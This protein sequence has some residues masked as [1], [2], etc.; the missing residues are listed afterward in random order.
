MMSEE[1]G[2]A[3][4]L[5]RSECKELLT[6][7]ESIGLADGDFQHPMLSQMA[8]ELRKHG[9]TLHGN[10]VPLTEREMT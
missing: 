4:I 10:K 8:G 3:F 2:L 7:L 9:Y 5:G 6:E 1:T